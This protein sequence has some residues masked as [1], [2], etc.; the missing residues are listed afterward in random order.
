MGMFQL[1]KAGGITIYALVLYSV[2]SIA[3][4]MER[5]IYYHSRSKVNREDF[6][7][8]IKNQLERDNLRHA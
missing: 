7:V 4:I 1:I 2:L 6:M 5:L 3:I 8:D